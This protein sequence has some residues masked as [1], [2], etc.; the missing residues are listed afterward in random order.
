[1]QSHGQ[2]FFCVQHTNFQLFSHLIKKIVI[3]FTKMGC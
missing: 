1:M 2:L 3:F